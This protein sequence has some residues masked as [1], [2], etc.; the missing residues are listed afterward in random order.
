MRRLGADHC[1]SEEWM[2]QEE[3][4]DPET[5]YKG[6]RISH[7]QRTEDTAHTKGRGHSTYKVQRT[8]WR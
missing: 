4:R 1:G 2:D 3:P 8:Q 7:T 5:R 6:H